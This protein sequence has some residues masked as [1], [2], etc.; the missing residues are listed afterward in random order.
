MMIL[1]FFYCR[2]PAPIR[3]LKEQVKKNKD[4]IYELR[5]SNKTGKQYQFATFF[6]FKYLV[7]VLEKLDSV[8]LKVAMLDKNVDILK[9]MSGPTT[10]GGPDMSSV[11]EQ[12]NDMNKKTQEDLAQMIGDNYQ[13]QQEQIEELESNQNEMRET[14]KHLQNE[15]DNLKRLLGGIGAKVNTLSGNMTSALS[16]SQEK[17]SQAYK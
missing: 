5:M 4:D 8:Q 13:K 6:T 10:A 9:S 1:Y 17:L 3:E 7:V 11:L 15:I 14:D 16:E 12:L 2:T